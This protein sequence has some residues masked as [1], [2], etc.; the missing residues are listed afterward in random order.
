MSRVVGPV[1]CCELDFRDR[2]EQ[3]E[4]V[5]RFTNAPFDLPASPIAGGERGD[6]PF[7]GIGRLGAISAAS[8]NT[9]LASE[10]ITVQ[11][12]GIPP[13]H[14]SLALGQHYQGR[15]A[16]IWAAF[17][18]QVAVPRAAGGE[19]QVV[20]SPLIFLGKIDNMAVQLGKTATMTINVRSRLADWERP[21]SMY[22]TSETH[23]RR[24]P[25]DKFFEFVP[26]MEEKEL[27]WG[28][29]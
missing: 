6:E 27:V 9:E 13:E 19:W 7:L 22:F 25:G 3:S 23:D 16:R 4:R 11:L 24:H 2:P 20:K 28:R 8:E 12:S 29:G 17:L 14:I 18:R 1:A 15:P 5:E 10:G 26:Q 21:R